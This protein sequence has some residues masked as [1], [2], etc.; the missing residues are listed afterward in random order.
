MNS[1]RRG[2]KSRGE[3]WY[4]ILESFKREARTKRGINEHAQVGI[5]SC[6][7]ERMHVPR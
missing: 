2:K 4:V 5:N 3:I 6:G 1:R 7:E